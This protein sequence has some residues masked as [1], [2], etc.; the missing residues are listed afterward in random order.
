MNNPIDILITEHELIDKLLRVLQDRLSTMKATREIDNQIIDITADCFETF[1]NRVHH[2]K[3]ENVLFTELYKKDLTDKHRGIIDKL[4]QEH[5][6]GKKLVYKIV[7][8]KHKYET[9]EKSGFDDMLE[10]LEKFIALY[11]PH[12]RFENTEFFPEALQYFNE[13]EIQHLDELFNQV[14]SEAVI[15]NYSLILDGLETK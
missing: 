5:V 6:V 9:G 13:E 15:R 4:S 7:E 1:I 8:A 11:I 2:W 3:E 14:E 12:L 10:Y